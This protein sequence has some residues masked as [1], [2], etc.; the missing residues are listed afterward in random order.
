MSEARELVPIAIVLC[1]ALPASPVAATSMEQ[2]TANL[3]SCLQRAAVSLDDRVSDVRIFVGPL[4]S[5]CYPQAN[6]IADN[7]ESRGDA[8]APL[9]NMAI[10]AIV[11]T[12]H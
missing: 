6:A 3:R 12:V 5:D 4:V 8:G 11:E 9:T 1:A 10:R 7:F 2:A